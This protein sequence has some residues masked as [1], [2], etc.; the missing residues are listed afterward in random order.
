[1]SRN[2]LRV[3]TRLGA[4]GRVVIPS[5]WRRRHGLRPGSSVTLIENSDGDLVLT[6]PLAALQ[7]LQALVRRHVPEGVSLVD[8]LLTERRAEA[9]RD[10]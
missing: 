9:E 1:M 6:T 8:E 5:S 2:H 3:T 7:N 4:G 10:H